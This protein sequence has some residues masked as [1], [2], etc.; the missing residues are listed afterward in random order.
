M[1]GKG[2]AGS[3]RHCC[4]LPTVM[5]CS[6][7]SIWHPQKKRFRLGPRGSELEPDI[8]EPGAFRD[9][10]QEKT[11]T[12]AP[13]VT[14]CGSAPLTV[15]ARSSRAEQEICTFGLPATGVFALGGRP[16]QARPRSSTADLI[17]SASLRN[18]SENHTTRPEETKRQT[19]YERR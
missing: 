7:T 10:S 2:A 1:K 11:N 8:R 13:E 5:K 15:S 17:R 16:V 9:N 19:E 3:V 14:E 18:N 12:R 4:L 6:K